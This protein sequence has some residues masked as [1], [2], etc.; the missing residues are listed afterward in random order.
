MKKKKLRKYLINK[1]E[2]KNIPSNQ[3]K[4]L[5]T[6][7]GFTLKMADMEK[8]EFIGECIEVIF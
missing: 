5:K 3:F 4:T 1:W 7:V 6:K 2:Y 8:R